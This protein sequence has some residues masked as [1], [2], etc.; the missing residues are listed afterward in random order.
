MSRM[1]NQ[2]SSFTRGALAAAGLLAG[3][4]L[5][6]FWPGFQAGVVHFSNDGPLGTQMGHWLKL[7]DGIWGMW[8]DLNDIGSNAGTY[9]L[10]VSTL[11]HWVLGPVGFAKFFQAIALLILGLGAWSLFRALKLS[12][13]AA[14]LGGLAAMLNSA[15]FGSACWGVGPQQVGIGM[16]FM[17]LALVCSDTAGV[18]PVLRWARVALAG[19]CV[20]INVMEAADIGAFF[21]LFVAAF[22]F[23]R[24]LVQAE[25]SVGARV[26]RGMLQVVVIGVF[27]LFLAS[28]SIVSLVTTQIQG[29]AGQGAGQGST[30]EEKLE[31]WDWASQWSLPKKETLGLAIPG[32][33]GYKMDTPNNVPFLESW[34][35]GGSYWGGIGRSP[36]L[37]RFFD[38]GKEG[39]A[40]PP[41][42][43]M[44]FTGGE[45]YAGFLVL[46]IGAWAVAQSLRAK[47][48]SSLSSQHR[49]YVWFFGVV[50]VITPVLAW[51]RFDPL[52]L[53]QH[54]IYQLPYFS[55]I[56]NP[57]KMLLI[58]SW[59]AAIL[60]AFGVDD[61]SRRFLNPASP[62]GTLG[63]WWARVGAFER[64]WTYGTLGV[65]GVSVLGW[66]I[67][68]SERTELVSFLQRRGFEDATLAGQIAD[69]SIAQVG[70]FVPL[71]AA[72]IGLVILTIAGVFAGPR[73]RLG[74]ALLGILLVLD[75]GHADLPSVNYWNAV[76]KY[77]IGK[78]NPVVEFLAKT[79]WENRVKRLPF[80]PAQGMELF[81]SVYDIEWIQQLF[82][83]YNIQSLDI[84][85]RPRV[86]S[87]IANYESSFMPH[88]VQDYY[89]IARQWSLTSTRYLVGATALQLGPQTVETVSFLNGALDPEQ[90]RFHILQ[91]FE[92]VPKAGVVQPRQ[93]SDLTIQPDDN[94]KYALFEFTGAVPRASLHHQWVVATNDSMALRL[95]T[96][97]NFDPGQSVVLSTPV[98][99][100]SPTATVTGEDHVE[101]QSY[102]PKHIVIATRSSAPAVL[103]LNDKYDDSWRVQVDGQPAPLLRANYIMRAVSLPAGSHVVRFDFTQPNLPLQITVAAMVL[104][105]GLAGFVAW[106]SRREETKD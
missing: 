81:N 13:L 85:Q 16:D 49:H 65:L 43:M 27:A 11:V 74:G 68:G 93:Y 32:L 52:G 7:P 51:G 80:P 96:A 88:S 8:G 54:T 36:E 3:V 105:L 77:E 33:F 48:H 82:P 25:G 61:L 63:G 44:R 35:E 60:F 5:L 92:V 83:Y 73:A 23:V 103:L 37:D 89:L 42:G 84:V 17:A 90:K 58:F 10:D 106:A 95:I 2:A 34:Y 46:L 18:R 53:Y 101:Y 99:G 94:G 14:I 1:K 97:T 41:P 62:V 29:V 12:P 70:W 19:I 38:S 66:F 78:L 22:V 79:P 57:V 15:F 86:G 76:E 40:T 75:L 71:V 91:R 45:N 9:W 24:A 4:L 67:Y 55:S 47:E 72:S 87:D 100:V 102:E 26:G 69:F 21:S 39:T 31:H 59:A 104:G 50:A 56:R 98:A 64:K 30:P 6:F 28:Q 20:G